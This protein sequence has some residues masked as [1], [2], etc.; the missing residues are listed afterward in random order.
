MSRI[1]ENNE[2][3]R[4]SDGHAPVYIA[5]SFTRNTV[6][7]ADL[8]LA[9]LKLPLKSYILDIG[10]GPGRHAVELVKRAIRLRS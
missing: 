6:Q 2:W 1:A 3:E 7:E 8:I 9:E 5:N 4:F 10:C